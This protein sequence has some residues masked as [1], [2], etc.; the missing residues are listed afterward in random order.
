MMEAVDKGKMGEVNGR[1][2]EEKSQKEDLEA[3]VETC[4]TTSST[5]SD[6]LYD[7]FNAIPFCLL[8]YESGNSGGW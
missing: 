2:T 7:G 5:D 4:D 3:L 6:Y 8:A 1:T